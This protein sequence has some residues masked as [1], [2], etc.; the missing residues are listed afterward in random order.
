MTTQITVRLP[1]H[2]VCEVDRRVSA[3]DAASRAELVSQALSRE[4]R[5]RRAMEDLEQLEPPDADHDALLEWMR[6]RSIPRP[7]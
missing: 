3:G 5:R 1:D 4:L 2:M 6:A 7:G